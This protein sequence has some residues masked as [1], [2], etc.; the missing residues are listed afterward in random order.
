MCSSRESR[1]YSSHMQA[2]TRREPV[3]MCLRLLSLMMSFPPWRPMTARLASRSSDSRSSPACCLRKGRHSDG[4]RRRNDQPMSAIRA[5]PSCSERADTS[6]HSC[7]L[8]IA[9]LGANERS[10]ALEISKSHSI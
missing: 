7:V 6:S 2:R 1:E 8:E 10:P 5:S 9:G 3:A 4:V